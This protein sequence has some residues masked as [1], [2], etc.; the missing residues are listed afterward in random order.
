MSL[1]W[2]LNGIK[3]YKEVCW[4]PIPES[5]QTENERVQLNPTTDTMIW[6]TM[7]VGMPCITEKNADEFFA[8]VRYHERLEGTLKMRRVEGGEPIEVY[9][10]KEDVTKHIGLETN[11]CNYTRREFLQRKGKRL[12][13]EWSRQYRES[14]QEATV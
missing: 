2:N 6:M 11:A 8:R 3:N 1:N 7:I 10:T 14:M 12:L 13:D 9:T 5:E 4:V